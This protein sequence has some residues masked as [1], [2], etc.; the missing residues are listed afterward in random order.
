MTV[1]GILL[2][3]IN[4][5][6]VVAVLL[7]VGAVIEW[8]LGHLGWAP[9]ANMVNLYIAVVILVALYMAVA[10]IFGL[11]SVRVFPLA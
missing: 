1:G 2:G 10:L 9:S 8:G 7:L 6:I 11:P 3:L 5:A 4:I